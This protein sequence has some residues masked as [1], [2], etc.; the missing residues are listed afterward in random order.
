MKLHRARKARPQDG[1]AKPHYF[2][3]LEPDSWI[4]VGDLS[5]QHKAIHRFLEKEQEEQVFHLRF[6][7]R[8]FHIGLVR[9]WEDLTPIK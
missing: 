5:F 3:E 9:D 6:A 7:S 4:E 2:I 8:A 1:G